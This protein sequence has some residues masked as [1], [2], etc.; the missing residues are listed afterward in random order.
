[1][2]NLLLQPLGLGIRWDIE[3][4]PAQAARALAL[5]TEEEKKAVL[6]YY[7]V[8][9]AKMSLASHLLKHWVVSKH[10][11][12]PWRATTLTRDK[13][14]KPIFVDPATRRQPVF[15]NVSHQAGL[16]AL[17][18]VAA[19]AYDGPVDVGT[20]IVCT[21]ERRARDLR[22]VAAEGWGAYVDMHADVFGRAEAASLKTELPPGQ[23]VDAK[24]RRFY[25]LW[26]LR[27]AYVKMTG[28]A[29][30]APWLKDL[31][32][33]RFR[34]PAPG[35]AFEQRPEAEM[36]ESERAQVIT[37]HE[38]L[39]HGNRVEDAN[40]CL[41]AL[42]PDYMTCTALRT[43]QRKEDGLGWELGPFKFLT[44]DEIVEHAEAHLS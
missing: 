16:V 1:M 24:L 5:L 3:L 23:P 39:F 42:G 41:R 6:K 21:S 32:F 44:L 38:V 13:N 11:G 26:C 29:L 27:E 28:E 15:F 2:R 37:D 20:D 7:F 14:G 17:V 35:T 10:A 25:T 22:L 19:R 33:M 12:V 34:A 36:E 18:A 31:N 40:I 30:L 43:P 8:A 4:T 9:D